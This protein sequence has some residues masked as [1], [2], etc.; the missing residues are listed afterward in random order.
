VAACVYA[1]VGVFTVTGQAGQARVVTAGAYTA[2]Q[3]KT[4]QT[5]Y[6]GMCAACHGEM[7]EGVI[8]PQLTGTDFQANWAGHT[9]ADLVEKITATMP[10]QAPGTLTRPQAINLSAFILQTGKYPVG[11]ALTAD[12]LA[13]VTFPGTL[14]AP[15]A[16]NAGGLPLAVAAN[17]RQLMI[18]VTFPN[19]NI[20]FNTQLKDPADDKGKPP[21]PF[22]YVLWGGT[23]YHG[24]QQVD[25]AAMALQ[26]TSAL[27]LMPGRKCQN[28]RPV[29]I[30][31][32]DF[33]KYTADL[34]AFAKDVQKIALTRDSSKVSDLSER[35][36]DVCANCHKVYR[37]VQPGGALQSSSNAG[38]IT[39]DRCNPN[40]TG[41]G[42]AQ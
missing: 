7:L 6:A 13:S 9:V 4:G 12:T 15:V 5:L 38:G 11:P 18:G 20:I 24:W 35:L 19:A 42:R 37:D 10:Q 2:D 29:P 27:F 40:P 36:N 28:G 41:V 32:A 8:G 14:A 33:Q 30:Q 16:V 25:H 1:L 23:A 39:A 21:V 26:E 22:D 34:I 31:N 3:A 17:L